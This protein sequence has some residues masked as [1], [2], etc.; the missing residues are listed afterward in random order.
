MSEEKKA[1][2]VDLVS[3]DV[4][5]Q[6]L[7]EE[8]PS[9]R[10]FATDEELNELKREIDRNYTGDLVSFMR[11]HVPYML[12]HNDPGND[13]Y[14]DALKAIYAVIYKYGDDEA[15]R[16]IEEIGVLHDDKHEGDEE[17]QHFK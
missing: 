14:D 1:Y 17:L 6:N 7:I 16:H 12:Y 13:K 9:F 10:I 4:L 8:N 2:Y 3:G 11:A 15:K 5:E